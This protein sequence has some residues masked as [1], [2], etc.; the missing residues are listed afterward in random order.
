M[1]FFHYGPHESFSCCDHTFLDE[2]IFHVEQFSIIILGLKFIY[3]G[4]FSKFCDIFVTSKE[5]IAIRLES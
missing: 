1:D 4:S 2:N 3:D 5:I